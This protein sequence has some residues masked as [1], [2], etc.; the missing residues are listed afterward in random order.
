MLSFFEA[1]FK[2]VE[3]FEHTVTSQYK[4]VFPLQSNPESNAFSPLRLISCPRRINLPSEVIEF[5]TT[6][7]NLS[8][9]R[10]FSL[11]F[12]Y[13]IATGRLK[14]IFCREDN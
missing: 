5:H 2:F 6:E 7:L 9:E 4:F 1:Y 8:A 12:S 11:S 10:I 13:Q 14:N 3:N